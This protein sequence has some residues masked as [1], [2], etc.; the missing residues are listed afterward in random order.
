MTRGPGWPDTLVIDVHDAHKSLAAK[1]LLSA[2][3]IITG[4]EDG[5]PAAAWDFLQ[6]RRAGVFFDSL[7]VN[8]EWF[9][10]RL[11]QNVESIHSGRPI[12][13]CRF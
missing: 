9:L 7:D 2:V 11:V 10:T 13:R 5:D 12:V 6:G 8:Q 4:Q 3:E 1:I